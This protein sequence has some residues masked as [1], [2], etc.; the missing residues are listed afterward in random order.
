MI[1]PAQDIIKEDLGI[2]NNT[3]ATLVLSIFVLGFAIG[4][5][6]FSPLS[7][8]YGRVPI[9]HISNVFFLAFNLGCGFAQNTVQILV[10]RFLA[11][12]FGIGPVVVS[13]PLCYVW[14]MRC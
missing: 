1:S 4:P 6:L 13:M 11:G 3:L 2:P 10:L 14:W 5:F 9:L 8:K 12:F 7:E